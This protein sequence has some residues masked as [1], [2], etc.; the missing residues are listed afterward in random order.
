MDLT[1]SIA[2]VTVP[3]STDMLGSLGE[4]TGSS[5]VDT[6]LALPFYLANQALGII[7]AFGAD[8]ASSGV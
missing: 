1:G 7:G 6:L 4:G 3:L 8:L 5:A 2:E